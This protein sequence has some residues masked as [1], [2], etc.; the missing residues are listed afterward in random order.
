MS[1]NKAPVY[2]LGAHGS[3]G[4]TLTFRESHG[5]T[6]VEKTP[7]LL[8]PETPAQL[9]HRAIFQG[10]VSAWHALPAAEKAAYERLGRPG[11]MTGYAYFMGGCIH[12]AVI[13]VTLDV[14]A[15]ANGAVTDPGEGSFTFTPNQ[16]VD[17]LAEPDSGYRFV[18]WTGDIGTIANPAAAATTILMS[19]N[20]TIQATFEIAPVIR[21]EYYITGDTDGLP[22]YA[23]YYVAQTFTPL[24]AHDITYVRVK[25]GRMAATSGTVTVQIKE[26]VGGKP[27]GPVLATGSVLT[28]IFPVHPSYAFKRVDLVAPVSLDD[29][30]MYALVISNTQSS[31]GATWRADMSP[32][33]Y[34]RGTSVFSSNYGVSWTIY[35]Y[36]QMFE[37]WGIEA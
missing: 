37:E 30:K 20:F 26:T 14:S 16:V 27:F 21:F 7:R 5:Q 36:D 25:M 13:S 33:G 31:P 32:E 8:D 6:I 28:Q 1:R 17:L 23:Q 9:A 22:C 10:C 35:A 12:A 15:G 29:G 11:H 18:A 24:L 34:T 4:K 3:I 19:G 2:S